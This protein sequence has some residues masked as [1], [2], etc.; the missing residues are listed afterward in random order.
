MRIGVVSASFFGFF[1]APPA[2][3]RYFT[4]AE[5][6]TA[7]GRAGRRDQP[8][9]VAGAVRRTQRRARKQDPDRADRLHH[10]RRSAPGFVGLWD[11]RPPAAFI[12][13]TSYGAEPE[14]GSARYRLVDDVQLGLDVDDRAPKA[15]RDDRRRERRP[16]AG[17]A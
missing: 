6:Q 9:D 14:F 11:D 4:E 8:R 7:G 10:H 2:L 5:D 16:H 12:P 1:D 17:D 15:R 3:G 13:I